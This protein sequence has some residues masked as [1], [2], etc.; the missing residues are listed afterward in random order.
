HL[1]G[2]QPYPLL[3]Q[4]GADHMKAPNPRAWLLIL[5]MAVC[6][7]CLALLP[8][9]AVV[10]WSVHDIA[11]S[12]ARI[13]VG[14]EWFA[15]LMH[16]ERLHAALLRQALF[17]LGALAVEI[18]LGI[19]LALAMPASGWRAGLVTVIVALPLFI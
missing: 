17:S 3:S 19:A 8:L 6:V 5:P 7:A 1:P 14:T 15:A 10:G 4:P 9:A 2:Q 13:F 12:G 11:P 18:P 16:D